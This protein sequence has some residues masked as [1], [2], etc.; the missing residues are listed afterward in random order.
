MENSKLS[1]L[2][3]EVVTDEALESIDAGAEVTATDSWGAFLQGIGGIFGAFGLK[4]K[5]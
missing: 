3:E 2:S 1:Q 5:F 4:I